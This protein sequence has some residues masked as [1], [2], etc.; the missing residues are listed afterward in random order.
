MITFLFFFRIHH[1][2][3]VIHPFCDV[4]TQYKKVEFWDYGQEENFSH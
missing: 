3:A 2:K 1:S 4:F